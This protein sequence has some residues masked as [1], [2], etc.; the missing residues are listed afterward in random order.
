MRAQILV[1]DHD[2]NIRE[3]AALHLRAAGYSVRLAEDGI[4][5]GYAV[6]DSPPDLI[7]CERHM[8]RMSGLEFVAALRADATIPRMPVLFLSSIDDGADCAQLG[9]V[10]NLV[11]PL[12]ADV[13]LAAVSKHLPRY[14]ALA[15]YLAPAVPNLEGWEPCV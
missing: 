5:A 11:K 2:A 10:E 1:V 14:S 4:R 9:V 6:L 8:P 15:D 7:L 13:L 12:R 3:L